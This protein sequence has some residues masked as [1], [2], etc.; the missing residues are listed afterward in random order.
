MNNP[1]QIMESL[2]PSLPER[3]VALGHKFLKTRDFESL[4][5]LIDSAIIKV[6]KGLMKEN[7]REEYLKVDMERLQ[8]LK[9]EVDTYYSML[10]LPGQE[11]NSI[12]EDYNEEFNDNYY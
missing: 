9:A 6:K 11:E 7:P 8:T 1:I 4:K 12:Y 10:E 2:I 3:D 5:M